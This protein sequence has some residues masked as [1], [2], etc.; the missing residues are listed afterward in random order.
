MIEEKYNSNKEI[1]IGL[2]ID[3]RQINDWKSFKENKEPSIREM[4]Q[5]SIDENLTIKF[6]F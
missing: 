5:T 6:A 1:L 2:T 3:Y 4:I